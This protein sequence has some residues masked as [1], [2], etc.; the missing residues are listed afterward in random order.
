MAVKENAASQALRW[1]KIGLVQEHYSEFVPFLRDVMD[2]L[3]FST[4]EIQEDIGK[5]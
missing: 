2:L 1:Q 5:F 4:S 3:G